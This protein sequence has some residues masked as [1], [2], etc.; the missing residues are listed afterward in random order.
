MRT[1]LASWLSECTGTMIAAHDLRIDRPSGGGWSNETWIVTTGGQ[2]HQRVVVRLQ[3]DQASM[4]PT[5]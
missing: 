2:R 4:F 1:R 3:P 5:P